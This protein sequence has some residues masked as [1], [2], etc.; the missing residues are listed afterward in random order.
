MRLCIV[1]KSFMDTRHN[2]CAHCAFLLRAVSSLCSA[3]VLHMTVSTL[4]IDA[5]DD[6][7]AN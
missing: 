4:A 3:H 7:Q 2:Y 5:V 1:I 6:M